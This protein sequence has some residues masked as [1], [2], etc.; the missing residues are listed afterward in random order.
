MF[1]K[2]TEELTAVANAFWASHMLKDFVFDLGE[3]LKEPRIYEI[4]EESKDPET[5]DSDFSGSSLNYFLNKCG[6][7]D[8]LHLD[9]DRA[10]CLYN[11]IYDQTTTPEQKAADTRA[12]DDQINEMAK[13][14]LAEKDSEI[15]AVFAKV[16]P[17]ILTWKTE[18][19]GE[20]KLNTEARIVAFLATG[21]E[22]VVALDGTFK[23]WLDRPFKVLVTPNAEIV[24]IEVCE[25]RSIQDQFGN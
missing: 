10:L 25:W 19:F 11:L 12:W 16:K 1:T 17:A 9:Q 4:Y 23:D 14:N 15:V 13:K 7:E 8:V 6:E 3:A 22:T 24:G 20:I 18:R 5:F 2:T 21:Y